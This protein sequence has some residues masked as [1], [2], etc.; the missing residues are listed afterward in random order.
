MIGRRAVADQLG[1]ERFSGPRRAGSITKHDRSQR[2][3][4]RE[5]DG[6]EDERRG[7]AVCADEFDRSQGADRR[8]PHAGAED[9]DGHAPSIRRKPGVDE[10]HANRERRSCDAEEEAT[11][12]QIGQAGVT[13][14]PE[15]QHRNDRHEGDGGKHDPSAEPVGERT[16]RDPPERSDEYRNGDQQGLLERRQVQR[17]LELRREW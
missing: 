4:H 14:Q 1:E 8:A 12:E 5:D 2:A 6:R 15:E 7:H 11:D 13:G 17:D 9:A 10:R 3:V 16:D